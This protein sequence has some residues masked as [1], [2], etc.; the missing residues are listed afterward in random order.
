[1]GILYL[2]LHFRNGKTSYDVEFGVRAQVASEA[3]AC[4][5]FQVR[6]DHT[7]YDCRSS[8]YQYKLPTL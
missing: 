2:Q 1:M 3:A 4:Q 5:P 6:A 7:Y 8:M